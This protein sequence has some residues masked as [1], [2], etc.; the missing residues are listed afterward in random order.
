MNI[1][2]WAFVTLLVAAG[3]FKLADMRGFYEIVEAYR[4]LPE[5]MVPIAS[6]ALALGEIAL[7]LWL[8]SGRGLRAA[9]TLLIALHV[10]YFAWISVAA[11][12]GLDITN[13]GC[14][15]VYWPRPLTWLTFVED[16]VLIALASALKIWAGASR[17]TLQVLP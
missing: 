13:C 10:V 2:R 11:A 7:A 6:W 3:G 5:A 16:V 8:A 4:A 14:F 9:A 15:G 17:P 12:R 1:L